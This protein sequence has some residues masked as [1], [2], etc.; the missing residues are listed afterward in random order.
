MNAGRV[1][2][3]L[4]TALLACGSDTASSDTSSST[5]GS[6][7]PPTSTSTSTPP[8]TS[9]TTGE[10]TTD[11]L[12]MTTAGTTTGPFDTSSTTDATTRPVATTTTSAPSPETDTT[13]PGLSSSAGDTSTTL[14]T[15]TAANAACPSDTA[16]DPAAWSLSHGVPGE[17]LTLHSLAAPP[18]AIVYTTM[19][20]GVLDL[21]GGPIDTDSAAHI[22]IASRTPAGA[23]AWAE[24]LGGPANTMNIS[25][26]DAAT[27]C[28]GNLLIGGTFS[29]DIS[30]Q[31]VTLSASPGLEFDDGM[32]FPTVD[33]FLVKFSPDGQLQ[34][35]HR[36]G[37]GQSQRFRGLDVQG[38][39]TVV[40]TADVLGTL[41]L[42]GPPTVAPGF[43]PV[44]VLAA[45]AGDGT[46]AWQR[47]FSGSHGVWPS[48][49]DVGA[50]DQISLLAS[51]PGSVDL[52][53]GVLIDA[54]YPRVLAQFAADGSHRWSQ[55][56][57]HPAHFPSLVAADAVGGTIVTGYTAPGDGSFPGFVLRHDSLGVFAWERL[58]VPD[59]NTPE[60]VNMTT[61]AAGAEIVVGGRFTGAIDFGGGDLNIDPPERAMFVVRLGLGGDHLASSAFDATFDQIPRVI[62]FGPDGE[63][64]LGGMFQGTLDLGS[65]PLI[66]VGAHDLF[67]HRFAP[68]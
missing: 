9:A 7:D 5:D 64:V 13:D 27:D 29:G 1:C 10:T 33:L 23:F 48:D 36:F 8:T 32:A 15:T 63:L 50:D 46:L 45:F 59:A 19:S 28:A 62:A 30:T 60:K 22:F 51:V 43:F 53:G 35:A 16:A 3:A 4:T 31:G 42:G 66:A 34:W 44:G 39:G 24:H 58:F 52:G 55:R 25:G 68:G 67:V 54:Q 12:V 47:A 40:L 37:D 2:T 57:K 61:V 11:A 56:F 49:L 14:D 38:D 65:G 17:A 18:G 41:D 20:A 6:G 21:G 26:F